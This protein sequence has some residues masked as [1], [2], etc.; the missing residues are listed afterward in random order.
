MHQ[1]SLYAPYP[2]DSSEDAVV[3]EEEQYHV[4]QMIK[5]KMGKGNAQHNDYLSKAQREAL[6][7]KKG[8]RTKHGD[9]DEFEVNDSDDAV[10]SGMETGG[11]IDDDSENEDGDDGLA[12]AQ[13]AG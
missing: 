6:A 4:E 1:S 10:L 11:Y 12:L 9:I 8:K 2:V 13:A 5:N 7:K 3:D